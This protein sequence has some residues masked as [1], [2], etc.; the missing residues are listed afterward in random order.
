MTYH[1][2]YF[3]KKEDLYSSGEDITASNLEHCIAK[4][5]VKFPNVF[6]F[7]ISYKDDV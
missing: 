4:F 7:N 2:V 6:I 1:F 3:E 5:R